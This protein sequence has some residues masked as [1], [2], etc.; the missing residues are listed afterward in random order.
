MSE[1]LLH[2]TTPAA[3]A[4]GRTAGAVT[5]PSLETE[6]FIHCSTPAQVV[7]TAD[8]VFRGSGDLLALVLDPDRLDAP[9]RYEHA[10]VVGEAFPHVY[11]RLNAG[12]IVG[13]VTLSEGPDGYVLPAELR[14][15]AAVRRSAQRVLDRIRAIPEGFVRTYGDLSP[16]APRYTGT[17]LSRTDDPQLPWWRV[18]HADGTLAKGERQR[19][20]LEAEGVPFRGN[21]VDLRVARIGGDQIL[22]DDP[23]G[24]A[25]EPF[26]PK[27]R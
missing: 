3:G 10:D 9:L 24:N 15:A 17:V 23:S 4:A 19:A 5:A 12:A 18:V 11:G 20:L 14:P 2:I 1:P 8:R 22:V 7:A 21:R 26:Q 13:T 25:V 27:A 6:G 16:G